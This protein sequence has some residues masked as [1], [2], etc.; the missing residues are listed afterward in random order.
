MCFNEIF[1]DRAV[2]NEIFIFIFQL[3]DRTGDA[4]G[5]VP[6]PLVLR[7]PIRIIWEHGRVGDGSAAAYE[8]E[9]PRLRAGQGH[10][11]GE[12]GQPLREQH[13]WRQQ[14]LRAW[15]R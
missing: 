11:P 4:P 10:V 12:D 14:G 5:D 6:A 9:R 13:G 7:G 1:D 2:F 15:S 8:P 3:D